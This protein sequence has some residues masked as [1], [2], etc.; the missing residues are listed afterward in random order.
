MQHFFVTVLIFTD[1]LCCDRLRSNDISVKS[2]FR[3]SFDSHSNL[4]AQLFF[5]LQRAATVIRV[6]SPSKVCNISPEI[7]VSTPEPPVEPP[8]E[9]EEATDLPDMDDDSFSIERGPSLRELIVELSRKVDSLIAAQHTCLSCSN[10][11]SVFPSPVVE[12]NLPNESTAPVYTPTNPL[13]APIPQGAQSSIQDERI[14]ELRARSCSVANFAKNLVVEF[15][16]P[17]E[18]VNRNCNGVKGKQALEPERMAIIK[19]HCFRYFTFPPPN[20]VTFG[21]ANVLLPSTST[22]LEAPHE[23][24]TRARED[25]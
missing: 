24:V 6:A 19:Q 14:L 12:H 7:P 18:L 1:C 8:M 13:T 4:S 25:R 11:V 20:K 10:S 15:F 3:N 9:E 17:T 21:P 2:C 22:V 5:L 23:N 16:S